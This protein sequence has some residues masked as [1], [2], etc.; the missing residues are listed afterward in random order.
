MIEKQL[1]SSKTLA[2]EA[3]FLFLTTRRQFGDIKKSETHPYPCTTVANLLISQNQKPTQN[4]C[5]T[6]A[7]LLISQ[8]QNPT[9]IPWTTVANLLISQVRNPPNPWTAVANFVSIL[10]EKLHPNLPQPTRISIP[11][12]PEIYKYDREAKYVTRKRGRRIRER[13][14]LPEAHSYHPV[15]LIVLSQHNK[16]ELLM[17]MIQ[18]GFQKGPDWIRPWR[19][20]LPPSP[21]NP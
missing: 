6:V 11:L 5:T 16:P 2:V 4:T 3:L 13:P 1:L 21:G 19:P 17:S 10:K 20:W 8:N 14:S 12:G 7:N 15:T 18:V 9:Q